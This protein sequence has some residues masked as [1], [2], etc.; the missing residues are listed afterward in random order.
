MMA[1]FLGLQQPPTKKF[2]SGASSNESGI[3]T[4]KINFLFE[5]NF[6]LR[7]FFFAI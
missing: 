2:R 3:K 5:Q 6:N 4:K 7:F 1:D